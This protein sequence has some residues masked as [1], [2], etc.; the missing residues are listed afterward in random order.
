MSLAFEMK[1]FLCV[2]GGYFDKSLLTNS[3]KMRIL[4][5]G[6]PLFKLAS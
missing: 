3:A 2:K 1:T 6:V 5:M 4:K